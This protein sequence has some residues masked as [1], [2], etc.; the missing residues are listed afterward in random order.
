[1]P[2]I[3]CSA[4]VPSK[5]YGTEILGRS[6]KHSPEGRWLPD[7]SEARRAAYVFWHHPAQ[8]RT[9]NRHYFFGLAYGETPILC[10]KRARRSRRLRPTD[11]SLVE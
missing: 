5:E 8:S 3:F 2:G 11:G 6:Q 4:A 1:M 7:V 9:E 10:G